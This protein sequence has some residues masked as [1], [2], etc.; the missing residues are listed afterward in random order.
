MLGAILY[1]F[2]GSMSSIWGSS[3]DGAR[4]GY[5]WIGSEWWLVENQRQEG[6]V[7]GGR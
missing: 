5:S 7:I 3:G 1:A 6:V 2:G 4:Y